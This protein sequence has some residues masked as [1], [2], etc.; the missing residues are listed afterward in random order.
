[1]N[2]KRKAI[3]LVSI[4]LFALCLLQACDNTDENNLPPV[5]SFKVGS[6][7]AQDNDT[8]EV[9]KPL[10]FGIQARGLNEVITNFT[11]KKV[12][13]DGSYTVVMDTGLYNNNLDLNKI[14]YQN[15][16]DIAEWTF[17]VMDKNRLSAEISM[18][19]YKD[20]NSKFGGIVHIPSVILGY[21]DNT[22]FGHFFDI[23][24]NKVYSEDSAQFAQTSIDFLTYFIVDDDL[25]SPVFSSPGEM[26]H[27]SNDA[28]KFYPSIAN[29]DTRKYVRWDV[30]VDDDPVS[31][32][33]YDNCHNDSLLI[34]SYHEVW[35]KMKFKWA[36]QG[37]VIPFLTDEGKKGLVKVIRADHDASGSVEFSLKMQL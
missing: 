19:I 33:D 1:M 15:V 4:V 25:P 30:S 23:N 8:I 10:F 37:R 6:D 11:I 24:N 16:E 14:F 31:A 26:D 28:K 22:E 13:T 27:F 9:G 36:T 3:R 35:G 7:Y 34:V 2:K 32:I 18:T 17:A 29:W 20:P 5:I 21:Q 12:Y